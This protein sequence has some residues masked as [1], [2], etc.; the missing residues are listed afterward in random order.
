LKWTNKVISKEKRLD[1]SVR[2]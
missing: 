2:N 1:V